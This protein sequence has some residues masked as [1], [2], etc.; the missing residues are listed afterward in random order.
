MKTSLN[1]GGG[2]VVSAALAVLLSAHGASAAAAQG[3]PELRGPV[4]IRNV[5]AIP[6]PGERIESATI[7]VVGGRIAAVGG[8]I[9]LPPGT[10]ELDGAGLFAYAGFVDGLSRAGVSGERISEAEEQRV[11]GEFPAMDDGPLVETSAANRNGIFARRR[12]ED[13][14]SLTEETFARQREAG[15]T[16]ALVAPPRA[17]FGGSAAVLALGPGPLRESVLR[18]GVAPAASFSVPPQRALRIRGS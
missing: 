18:E 16:A 6:R 5:T 7:L 8:E 1:R 10:R 3:W 17:I 13:L 4:A 12:V 11:E 15:L 9:A 14:L 2:A